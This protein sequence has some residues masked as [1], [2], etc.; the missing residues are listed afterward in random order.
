MCIDSPFTTTKPPKHHFGL[1]S[2]HQF[3]MALLYSHQEELRHC[4]IPKPEAPIQKKLTFIKKQCATLTT[5]RTPYK[6]TTIIRVLN[7]IIG[8]IPNTVMW[9]MLRINRLPRPTIIWDSPV[10]LR[11][12]LTQTI[13]LCIFWEL[14]RSDNC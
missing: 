14:L 3:I 1:D 7:S 4:F 2:Y 12:F 13:K 8:H 5:E 9:K 6:L 11:I 10:G